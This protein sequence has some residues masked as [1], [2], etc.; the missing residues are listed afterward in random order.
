MKRRTLFKLAG[1]GALGCLPLLAENKPQNTKQSQT[2]Q[3]KEN[4]L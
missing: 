1:I 4:F 2:H 3:K